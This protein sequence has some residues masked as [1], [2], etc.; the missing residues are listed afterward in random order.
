MRAASAYALGQIG[1]TNSIVR[2]VL[3]KALSDQDE[4]VRAAAARALGKL[5]KTTPVLLDD[6][7]TDLDN[8]RFSGRA[9][10]AHFLGRLHI[11]EAQLQYVLIRLNRCLHDENDDVRQEALI[12]IHNIVAGRPL[13]GYRWV[14]L[15]QRM[16]QRRRMY[17]TLHWAILLI[18]VIMVAFALS[19]LDAETRL[20][21]VI[22][23]LCG[24]IS[25][26]AGLAQVVGKSLHNPWEKED[27]Q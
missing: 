26:A 8:P 22:T 25:I 13:P 21:Q 7:L 20:M 6:L 5:G 11:E 2:E 12:A 10:V 15:R 9:E 16:E 24:L 19:Y 18:G 1:E 14:P 4:R 3:G 23:V 17:A 27:H